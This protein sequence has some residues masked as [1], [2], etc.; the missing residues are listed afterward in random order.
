MSIG[1]SKALPTLTNDLEIRRRYLRSPMTFASSFCGDPYGHPI[2]NYKGR[3]LLFDHGDLEGESRL[4]MTGS[5]FKSADKKVKNQI[6][7]CDFRRSSYHFTLK[8]LSYV[9]NYCSKIGSFCFVLNSHVQA[10]QPRA[11]SFTFSP[12]TS[13][14]SKSFD[15]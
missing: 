5:I 13:T 2:R 9:P 14:T 6:L 15:A 10:P 3:S 12:G 11:F 4:E 8:I 1:N 7:V